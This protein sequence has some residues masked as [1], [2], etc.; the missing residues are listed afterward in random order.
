M[1]SII[2]ILAMLA[3]V[4][5]APV[6]AQ[7][8][9]SSTASEESRMDFKKEHKEMRKRHHHERKALRAEQK[10][11]KIDTNEDGKLDL[12][13]YLA[14]AEQRFNDMDLDK[15]GFV[16]SEESSEWRLEMRSKHRKEKKEARKA[17]RQA[18]SGSADNE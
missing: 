5:L 7:E 1:K 11:K 14:N 4:S 3:L 8:T 12:V 9:S 15:N 10:L 6:Q 18:K 16:T 2:P 17:H 13:E